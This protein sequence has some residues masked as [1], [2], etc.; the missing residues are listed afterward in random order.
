MFIIGI[1]F[2]IVATVFVLENRDLVTVTFLGWS[3]AVALGVALL[4][5]AVGGA[6]V[7]YV[8]GLIKQAQL[9]SQLRASDARVRDLER[10]RRNV[11]NKPE[12]DVDEEP[13]S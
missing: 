2:L 12:T 10:E 1:L 3:Y 9:R 8:S 7:I 4:V 6:V 11:L 13:G 5:A